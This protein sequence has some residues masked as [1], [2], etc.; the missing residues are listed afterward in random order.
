MLIDKEKIQKRVHLAIEQ[1]KNSDTLSKL[2]PQEIRWI[3]QTLFTLQEYL[4]SNVSDGA[5]EIYLEGQIRRIE[6]ELNRSTTPDVKE[7]L[8]RY[9]DSL[10][11]ENGMG[12]IETKIS[13]LKLGQYEE[14]KK[15]RKELDGFYKEAD[16][17]D[18][19][20]RERYADR[21]NEIE[22]DLIA[23]Y[24]DG[25][26][27]STRKVIKLERSGELKKWRDTL[28]SKKK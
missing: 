19:V 23:I 4:V 7:A 10:Y 5:F 6:A 13:S 20:F 24:T 8:K 12:N 15:L 22:G 28:K 2:S 14:A 11:L 1:A 25:E 9:F 26:M 27:G 17:I 21:L 16:K 18:P 3:F